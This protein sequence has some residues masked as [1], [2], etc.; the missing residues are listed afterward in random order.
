MMARDHHRAELP[1]AVAPR[2]TVTVDIRVPG[3]GTGP[4]DSG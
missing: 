3:S 4:D 2:E 1:N